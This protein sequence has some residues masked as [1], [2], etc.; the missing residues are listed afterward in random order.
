M[1]RQRVIGILMDRDGL[2]YQ[3]AKSKVEYVADKLKEDYWA[4]AEIIEDELGLE[5]DYLEDL[6]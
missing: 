6:L 4:A 3:E 2:S 1:S 5:S